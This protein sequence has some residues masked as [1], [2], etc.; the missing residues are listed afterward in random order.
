MKKGLRPDTSGIKVLSITT[1]GEEEKIWF[2]TDTIFTHSLFVNSWQCS[3]K[4][5]FTFSQ[6]NLITVI[7]LDR[8]TI[9]AFC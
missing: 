2:E 1:E 4:S 5:I 8:Y 9:S 6:N 3:F 7:T